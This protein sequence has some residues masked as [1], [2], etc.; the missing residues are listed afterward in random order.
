MTPDVW[1]LPVGRTPIRRACLYDMSN[2]WR[3]RAKNA[4][5]RSRLFVRRQKFLVHG[6]GF[7]QYGQWRVVIGDRGPAEPRAL[8]YST[9]VICLMLSTTSVPQD[10]GT[11]ALRL[12]LT[13][14]PDR[15]LLGLCDRRFVNLTMPA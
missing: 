9:G 2:C 7:P 8:S 6:F 5:W 13:V 15:N 14:A 1:R 4:F 3:T 12:V 10:L 11:V